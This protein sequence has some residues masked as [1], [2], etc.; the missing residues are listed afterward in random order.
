V[1]AD[2]VSPSSW[3]KPAVASLLTGL[4]PLRHQA[5]GHADAL[6][7]AARTLAE[8]LGARG[9]HSL[10][11]T[12]NGWLSREAGFAQ[13]FDAYHSMSWDLGHGQFS[14]AQQLNAELLPRLA[15]LAP[16]FFLYVHYLDPHAPYDP[17]RDWS[18]LPLPG[19]LARRAHGV[20]IQE[21]QIESFLRRPA[22]L[23][24]DA[25][26]LYDGEIRRSSDA[27]EELLAELRRGRL[28]AG[29]LT[30]LTSDHGEEL[31]EHGRMGHGQAL[32]AESVRVPLVFH[33]PGVI[34]AGG[35]LG[36]ASLLD[37]FPTVLELLGADP[38]AAREL[39][40]QSLGRA[41]RE[42]GAAPHPGETAAAREL[43]LHLDLGSAGHAI[44]LRGPRYSL[45]LGQG[46]S[47]KELFD[48]D[49]DAREQRNLLAGEGGASLFEPMAARLAEAHNALSARALSASGA[50]ERPEAA[51]AMAALGYVGAG[52]ARPLVR[53]IPPRIRP[54]DAR[55]EGSLGWDAAGSPPP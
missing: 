50:R 24:R 1:V 46:R 23:L 28:D 42:A 35:R 4:H 7:L 3:T 14:S 5:I 34:P 43:L 22:E 11:I 10:G 44:G 21:L 27:I 49:R 25:T 37:V 38:A 40:G 8:A 12:A 15:T 30:V 26:D 20:S 2:G 18:G 6:P 52:D 54:A 41:L 33:A 36:T 45:L 51:E 17:D 13:G 19:R 39:D 55:P 53:G 48:R 29:T 47:R 32:Y 31:E 9:C 16:P